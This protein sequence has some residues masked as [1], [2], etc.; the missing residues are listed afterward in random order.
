MTQSINPITIVKVKDVINHSSSDLH[1]LEREVSQLGE[2]SSSRKF[3]Q[4]PVG[5]FKF[6]KVIEME[7][8]LTKRGYEYLNGR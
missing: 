2:K 3:S 5:I 8:Y 4:D 1:Q 7:R 6:K